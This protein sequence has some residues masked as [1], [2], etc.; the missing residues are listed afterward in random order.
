MSNQN[1]DKPTKSIEHLKV[2]PKTTPNPGLNKITNNVFL[3]KRNTHISYGY[4][5][6]GSTNPFT[7]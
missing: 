1:A 4:I 2:F 3:Q 6:F 7:C 5:H